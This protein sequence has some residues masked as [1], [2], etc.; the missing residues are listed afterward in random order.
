MS[1][2][3]L[4]Q[5]PLH[6]SA[7]D[8]A[9]E[10]ASFGAELYHISYSRQ[11]QLDLECKGTEKSQLFCEKVSQ[12]FKEKILKIHAEFEASIE[13]VEEAE[14]IPPEGDE[15]GLSAR[16]GLMCLDRFPLMPAN[17]IKTLLSGKDVYGGDQL[18]DEKE[19]AKNEQGENGY[20]AVRIGQLYLK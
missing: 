15:G 11:A 1:K 17:K 13:G 19:L 4:R 7:P 6:P 8:G 18:W 16:H 2:T 12:F 20:H 3:Y 5:A 14:M 10:A 9:R